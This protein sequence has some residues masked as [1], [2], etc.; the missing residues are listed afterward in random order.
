MK[1]I[2]GV[3]KL[4]KFLVFNF[5]DGEQDVAW[6]TKEAFK[7][8]NSTDPISLKATSPANFTLNT[9]G[10][11]YFISTKDRHCWLGQKLAINV[12]EYPG[13]S[14]SPTPR[15]GPVT[16]TV[17]DDLGWLVPPGGELFYAAWAYDKIF[18][19][20]DTLGIS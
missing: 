5:T 11:Y 13:P 12:T 18:L 9:T 6:V 19:V 1:S 7:N 15:S 8:C 16:Y 3:C 4:W 17:G 10:E 20:G 2:T 14:P